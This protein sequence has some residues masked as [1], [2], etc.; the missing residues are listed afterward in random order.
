MGSRRGCS[1]IF[2]GARLSVPPPGRE[3]D[4]LAVTLA[5]HVSQAS[6]APIECWQVW[7]S[8]WSIATCGE[9]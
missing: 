1:L 2:R 4:E 7:Q 9:N 6:G 8:C 3:H 5:P